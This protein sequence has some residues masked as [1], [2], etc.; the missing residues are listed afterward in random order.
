MMLS[1]VGREIR[2]VIQLSKQGF[3]TTLKTTTTT[4]H[5]EEQLLH[6]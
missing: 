3:V 4:Q 6:S 5:E 1:K 2:R